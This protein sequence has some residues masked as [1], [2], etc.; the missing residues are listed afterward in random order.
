MS[1][2]ELSKSQVKEYKTNLYEIDVG[3]DSWVVMSNSYGEVAQYVDLVFRL[4]DLPALQIKRLELLF[5]VVMD[6]EPGNT[7]LMTP[8]YLATVVDNEIDTESKILAN[9]INALLQVIDERNISSI[10]LYSPRAVVLKD[11]KVCDV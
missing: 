11:V 5:R 2:S 9:S 10:S 3:G 8:L 1:E 4:K 7:S 6:M